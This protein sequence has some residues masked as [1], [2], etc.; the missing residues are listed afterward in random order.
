MSGLGPSDPAWHE[1]RR[2]GIG[3]SEVATVLGRHPFDSPWA[4]WA[5]KVGLAPAQLEPEQLT[6]DLDA[7]RFGRDLEAL[8]ARYFAERTGLEIAGEQ[9]ALQH[10][11]HPWARCTVDGLVFEAG[12]GEYIAD[13]LGVLEL[14]YTGQP[15]PAEVPEHHRLQVQWQL[16]VSG[17]GRGWLATIR[18]AFGRPSFELV[19]IERDDAELADV[20]AEVERW[21]HEHVVAGIAP[22]VDGSDATTAA[23]R[24]AYGA[25]REPPADAVDLSAEA[26]EAVEVLGRLKADAKVLAADIAAAENVLRAELGDATEGRVGG[27][28]AVSWRHQTRREHVV[29][30]STS[31]VLRLHNYRR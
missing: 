15:R 13:A 12:A 8:G 27:F 26:V 31:R 5:R 29:P 16:Y 2:Q 22:P 28:L 7:A 3:A 17:L 4:L 19:E 30:A 14:K 9:M 6:G 20:V 25:E 23:L 24:A 18:T 1:R 11:T 21:W 10:P